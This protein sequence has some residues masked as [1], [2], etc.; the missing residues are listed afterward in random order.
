[1]PAINKPL[2]YASTEAEKEHAK[3]NN[4]ANRGHKEKLMGTIRKYYSLM[5][6]YV[7]MGDARAKS[8][9]SPC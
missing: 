9:P 6:M 4:R 5:G 1:M 8:V 2:Y 3:S 7:G